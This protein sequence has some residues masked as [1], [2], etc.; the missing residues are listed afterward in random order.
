MEDK[1]IRIPEDEV[2][3][4]KQE[5]EEIHYFV[6][7]C[8]DVG[9]SRQINQDAGCARI[10]K[11]PLH[12]VVLAAVCDGA[13]GMEEG[14]YASKSTIQAFNNWFDYQLNKLVFEKRPNELFLAVCEEIK[15]LIHKQNYDV[16]GYGR[17][18]NIRIGTTLTAMIFVD[19]D[20][21][22]AQIGDSR[23]YLV[24][25]EIVQLTEDQSL[26]AREVREGRLTEEEAR[27]DRRR[28]I[29]LQCLGAAK[30]LTPVYQSGKVEK[31]ASYFLCSDGFVHQLAK[32]EMEAFMNPACMETIN[33]MHYRLLQSIETVKARGEK[34]NITVAAV[35]TW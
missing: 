15:L 32:G 23:A 33:Q 18:K 34:D 31:G 10:F 20:Y 9:I 17:K 7:C 26:V 8:T 13:G 2:L 28:N 35:R 5:N 14:E 21:F 30:D 1:T 11:T 3:R 16:F 4:E 27:F 6:D 29:I 24:S 25:K 12:T 22:I 19:E